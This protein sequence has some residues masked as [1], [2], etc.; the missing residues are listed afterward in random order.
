VYNENN[1]E[2]IFGERYTH[3]QVVWILHS[4]TSILLPE[5]VIT[6][7]TIDDPIDAG[8]CL[9]GSLAF[10]LPLVSSNNNPNL[11]T[12]LN[13]VTSNSQLSGIGYI[14]EQATKFHLIP[15]VQAQGFGFE[16]LAPI[17]IMWAAMRD[18]SYFLL[19]IAFIIMAFM[20][21]FRVRI[22]PQTVITVQSALP[23]LVFILILITFSY[24][25]AGFV[26]D[27]AYLSLGLLAIVGNNLSG[28]DTL[29]LFNQFLT[30]LPIVS[31][32]LIPMI[33][34]FYYITAP[35]GLGVLFSPILVLLG[36]LLTILVFLLLLIIA[37]RVLWLMIKT[38]INVIL[39]VAASPLLIL[40]GVFPA[41]GGFGSWLRNLTSH[42]VVFPAI[43]MMVFLAHFVFWSS[44]DSNSTI[45]TILVTAISSDSSLNPFDI[46]V[47][48]NNSTIELPGFNIGDP[49][50]FGAIVALGILAMVPSVGN[51]IQGFISGR[52]FAYGTAIGQAIGPMGAAWGS[53]PIAGVRKEL[54]FQ[55]GA[56]WASGLADS[57]VGRWLP[58][59]WSTALR[60]VGR[61]RT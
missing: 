3:A 55:Q 4:I 47:T 9:A 25:I 10:I 26:V 40:L 59:S 45:G 2:E 11:A 52:P 30:S 49:T 31:M 60:N 53:T 50:L 12:T 15:E 35:S 46:N 57:R 61:S 5:F 29:A 36:I 43:I 32:F 16:N 41:A 19:I 38:F 33:V 44:L 27:L 22:S 20:I 54:G 21:M 14:K 13:S 24:A 58:Q 34:A 42:V 51:I 56:A 48:T 17:R 8:E 6:C 23:R 37:I 1:P 28:L 39:L 18:I 7:M